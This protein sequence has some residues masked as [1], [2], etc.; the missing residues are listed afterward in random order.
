MEE[1]AEAERREAEEKNKK[2]ERDGGSQRSNDNINDDNS[3]YD[4]LVSQI[5]NIFEFSITLLLIRT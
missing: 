4:D 2:Q 5:N 3:C 1:I